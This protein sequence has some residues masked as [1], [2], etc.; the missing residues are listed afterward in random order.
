M[1]ANATLTPLTRAK[2]VAYH[3]AHGRS[4]RATATTFGVCEKTIRRW[5]QRAQTQGFPKRLD[6]RSSAPH[7]QPRRIA[8]ELET[9]ILDLRRDRRT[10]AQ[11]LTLTS[12]CS[13]M[14]S[15]AP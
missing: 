12:P 2:M 6:D 15:S 1:H 8:A 11:R 13:G 4:L 10:Y 9:Q 3:L 14:T 7:Q 5:L